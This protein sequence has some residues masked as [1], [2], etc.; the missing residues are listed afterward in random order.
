M[1]K[2]TALILTL[3]FTANAGYANNLTSLGVDANGNTAWRLTS[4]ATGPQTVGLSKHGGGTV[5]FIVN[6]GV[7][8]VV[9]PGGTGGTYIANFESGDRNSVTKASGAQLFSATPA[10]AAQGAP[11]ADGLDGI[12]GV[13]G[14]DIS[15][16][17]AAADRGLAALQTRAP[18]IGQWT[19]A[20][21]LSGTD[22]GADAMAFGLRY[23][24]SSRA[25]IYGVMSQSFDGDT[26]WG[27]GSTF[28]LGG[29]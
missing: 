23:G 13:D 10:P 12:D 17:R 28:V 2:S 8:N 16:S 7:T 3:L 1:M 24:I 5:S 20:A 6:P 27:V 29:S 4:T 15:M 26:S 9:V 19:G 25:D 14:R 22:D 21:G 18:M 11:G